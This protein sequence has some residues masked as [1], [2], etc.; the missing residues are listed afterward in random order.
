MSTC[1]TKSWD[2]TSNRK[3]SKSSFN[4]GFLLLL[5][6]FIWFSSF[7]DS[8]ENHLH[9][10]ETAASLAAFEDCDDGNFHAWVLPLTGTG[11]LYQDIP[12]VFSNQEF[13]LVVNA[14][15]EDP[16]GTHLVGL[17]FM[18]SG[19]VLSTEF[20]E[21]NNDL[22]ISGSLQSYTL[23]AIPPLLRVLRKFEYLVVQIVGI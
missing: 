22:N 9:T 16:D 8:K 1:T 20:V 7:A 2:V 6:A 15:V 23:T 11:E 19:T 5:L 4:R 13:S 12:V 10:F 17:Q 18:N 3:G 21:I 14:G